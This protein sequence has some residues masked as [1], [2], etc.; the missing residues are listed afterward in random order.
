[1]Q[2][3]IP[4]NQMPVGTVPTNQ[5][6]TSFHLAF[7]IVDH[8]NQWGIVF[9][10]FAVQLLMCSFLIAPVPISWRRKFLEKWSFYWNLYPRF[11]IVIKTVIGIVFLLFLDACRKMYMIHWVT[12]DPS[13]TMVGTNKDITLSLIGAQ[14]NAFLCGST[15]FLALLLNRFRIMVDRISDLE[16]RLGQFGVDL[17]HTGESSIKEKLGVPRYEKKVAPTEAVDDLGIRKR[18]PVAPVTTR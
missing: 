4:V 14:R 3:A 16:L 15:V 5:P 7:F 8:L 17:T 6:D 13:G 10:I 2:Q 11:R 9:G 18:V 1:M 12:I